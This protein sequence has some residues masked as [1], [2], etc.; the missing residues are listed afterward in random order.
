MKILT[1]ILACTAL[2]AGSAYAATP[3]D[4]NDRYTRLNSKM[5][6]AD[7]RPSLIVVT[8]KIGAHCPAT[9]LRLCPHAALYVD[10]DSGARLTGF[11][12]GGSA[13]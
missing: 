4:K 2:A 11:K 6:K 5:A 13:R 10:R 3:V 7:P 8:T 1:A 12:R 9:A